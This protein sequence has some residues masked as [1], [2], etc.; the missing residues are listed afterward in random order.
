MKKFTNQFRR[1]LVVAACLVAVLSLPAA[2]RSANEDGAGAFATGKYRNLFAEIGNGLQDG[3]RLP[4]CRQPKPLQHSEKS[5]AFEDRRNLAPGRSAAAAQAEVHDQE[6]CERRRLL[7]GR[8]Q[9][10]TAGDHMQRGEPAEL[11]PGQKLPLRGGHEFEVT[12]PLAGGHTERSRGCLYKLP[13]FHS[14]STTF[15]VLMESSR[16]NSRSR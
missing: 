3:D 15:A 12:A 10:R 16:G 2:D 6:R 13:A 5:V 14:Y 7:Q 8:Q 4:R 1:A 11:E 9:F